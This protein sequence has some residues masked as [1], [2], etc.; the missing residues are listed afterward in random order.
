MIMIDAEKSGKQWMLTERLI[1]RV[2]GG[3]K[4]EGKVGAS[5]HSPTPNSPAPPRLS[6]TCFSSGAKLKPG[7][8]R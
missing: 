2:E 7:P 8:M 5:L 4:V 1:D 3:V 6:K